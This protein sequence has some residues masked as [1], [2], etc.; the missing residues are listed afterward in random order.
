MLPP[1]WVA[2]GTRCQDRCQSPPQAQN[3][4]G[5][6]QSQLY[7]VIADGSCGSKAHTPTASGRSV[8]SWPRWLKVGTGQP[9]SPRSS[10]PPPLCPA[11][12]ALPC[13]PHSRGRENEGSSVGPLPS[14]SRPARWRPKEASSQALP[15][16]NACYLHTAPVCP[17]GLL[18]LSCHIRTPSCED[19]K[20]SR[21]QA[22]G[23]WFLQ[24]PLLPMSFSAL[25]LSPGTGPPSS[26]SELLRVP[27]TPLPPVPKSCPSPVHPSKCQRVAKWRVRPSRAHSALST[28]LPSLPSDG[29]SRPRALKPCLADMGHILDSASYQGAPGPVFIAELVCVVTNSARP[30]F[31]CPSNTSPATEAIPKFKSDGV[32]SVLRN[33]QRPPLLP[34][35]SLCSRTDAQGHQDPLASCTIF[36]HGPSLPCFLCP[37]T[38]ATQTP[39]RTPRFCLPLMLLPP[40]WAHS[41]QPELPP[42]SALRLCDVFSD[43]LLSD[44]FP[45]QEYNLRFQRVICVGHLILQINA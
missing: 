22:P 3:P 35:G 25:A 20:E 43:C 39:L 21:V 37:G 10:K 40:L 14:G 15:R 17:S 30:P 27:V 29:W 38:P 1:S 34:G 23:A 26:P 33:P 42:A 44:S 31:S 45:G 24:E 41:P 32:I 16:W 4:E 7:R 13:C 18:L 6:Q 12:W 11:S 19:W 2:V 9:V 28:L 8:T 36:V 5:T